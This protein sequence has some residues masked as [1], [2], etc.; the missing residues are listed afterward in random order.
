MNA[1]DQLDE[2]LELACNAKAGMLR[3]ADMAVYQKVLEEFNAAYRVR[4]TGCNYCMPCPKNVNIPGCFS[5]YNASF[6]ISLIEGLKQ[7]T[8]STA[9]TSRNRHTASLCVKCGKCEQH[10]PQHI[11][12]RDELVAVKRRLEPLYF[13]AGMAAARAFLRQN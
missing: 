11:A 8:T 10:C 9:A 12:I 2:N 5:A 1:Q 6:T 4:C 13:R 7:Y 3:D